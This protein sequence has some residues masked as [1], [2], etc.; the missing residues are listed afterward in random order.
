MPVF[1][2]PASLLKVGSV[3]FIV[4]FFM[5]LLSRDGAGFI[6]QNMFVHF[7][8]IMRRYWARFHMK[9]LNAIFVCEQVQY[10]K[11]Y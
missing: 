3:S 5:G 4:F 2:F 1:C 6:K 10:S 11:Q 7:E 8:Q 9:S